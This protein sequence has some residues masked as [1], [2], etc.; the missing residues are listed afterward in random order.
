MGSGKSDRPLLAQLFFENATVKV[1]VPIGDST[2]SG[3]YP[4]CD[5]YWDFWITAQNTYAYKLSEHEKCNIEVIKQVIRHQNADILQFEQL[6]EH[7]QDI[8]TDEVTVVGTLQCLY[9][10][11]NDCQRSVHEYA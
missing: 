11:D 3:D 5:K 9:T 8:D 4:L 10:V 7:H 6:L 2:I 1:V